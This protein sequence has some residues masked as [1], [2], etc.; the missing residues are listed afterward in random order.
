[1]KKKKAEPVFKRYVM[2]QLSL[3][4]P[5]LEELVP[6]KHVVRVVNE[7]IEQ[8]DLRTLLERYK[9]GGTSSYHPKMMLKV[10]VYGYSQRIYSS[11]K[12][13]KELREN[14]NF[15]WISGQNQPNFRTINRFR[16]E[17][18]KGIIQEVFAEVLGM[19]IEAGYIKLEEY[20]VDGTI[21]EANARKHSYVW[22][23]NTE[24]YQKQL[25]RTVEELLE[26]IERQNEEENEK[27]GDKDLEELGEDA[28]IDSEKL[29]KK[30]EEL[31]ERL[32]KRPKDKGLKKVVRKLEQDHL[33]RQEQYEQ[34]ERLLGERNSYSKTDPDATFMRMKADRYQKKAWPK[35]AYNVQIGTENQMIVGFSVHQRPG[36]TS[37]FKPHME[38]L[39]E[40]LPHLPKQIT[41]D[42]GYGSEENY[43]YLE[44]QQLE[45]YL[46]YNT[47][48][49]EQ[50]RKYQKDK[51]QAG[52]LPYDPEHDRFICPQGRFLTYQQTR[53]YTTDNGYTGTYD[54]YACQDCS[55]CEFKPDC[56]QAQGNRQ[57]QINWNLRRL[58]AQARTNLLSERGQTLRSRR[59]VEVEAVFG[60]IKQNR[61]F[62]R[63]MLRGLEKVST[64]WGLLSIAHNMLKLAAMS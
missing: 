51:F 47:F 34:Q 17:M 48:H 3:L 25:R 46:K 63:F 45:N 18:M 38:Q 19:L 7:A 21:V 64:E 14:V 62:R 57:I 44:E 56:T 8:L 1:M 4:P 12:I 26:E 58:R 36:D 6:E 13:A 39:K 11:R 15:M 30:I 54:V 2:G 61:Q 5:D 27:Y 10:L 20:Y 23:K 53:E 37:C 28:K 29:K 40:N 42:A 59:G 32:K 41:G 50:T 33:P 55:G 60:H 49:K 24:R 31:N 43:V 35:P 52:N 22:R 9:G 16:G